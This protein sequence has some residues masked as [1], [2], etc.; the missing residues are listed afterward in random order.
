LVTVGG[1]RWLAAA[2]GALALVVLGHNITALFFVGLAGTYGVIVAVAE[3]RTGALRAVATLVAS[4]L[5]A[6]VL[7]AI[8]WLPALLELGYSR[9]SE[10][11]SGDFNVTRYLAD[12]TALLQPSV[13]FD[14]YLEAVP[15]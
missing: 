3:R 6:L 1:P 8:Y 11:R 12:P 9:V 10:Q 4:V 14:Y 7:S 2:A 5:L 13:L 15:R